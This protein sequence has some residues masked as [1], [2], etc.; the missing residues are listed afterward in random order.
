MSNQVT[1]VCRDGLGG[2]LL[3]AQASYFVKAAGKHPV[4]VMPA[5]DE[6]FKPYKY[7]LEDRFKVIQA[8]EN[9]ADNLLHI[10]NDIELYFVYPDGLYQG[11]FPFNYQKYNTNPQLI[12]S[13]RI[14]TH[15]Y[16]PKGKNIYLGLI[17]STPGYS[18]Q[19]AP[20]LAEELAVALPDYTFH[21]ATVSKWSNTKINL[22]DLSGLPANV[23]IYRDDDFC[24]QIDI[25]KTCEYCVTLDSGISHISWNLGMPR[26]LLDSRFGLGRHSVPWIVRWFE[27]INEHIR[28][29]SSPED[30]AQLVRTN[31]KIP[32]TTLLPRQFVLNNRGAEWTREL[33]MKY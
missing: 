17:S 10:P 24:N 20:K 13:T 11:K 33:F 30:I 19:N 5:R 29:E 9:Y 26:L 32:Q 3:T 22:G 14:L 25:L 31:I 28:I 16:I 23:I 4:I 1:L 7:L 12:R 6:V 15:Q 21:L 27:D 2:S 8:P 18:Y